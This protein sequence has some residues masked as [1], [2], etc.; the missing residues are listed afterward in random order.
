MHVNLLSLP[1]LKLFMDV[2]YHGWPLK[3]KNN[4][5]L[6]WHSHS[7]VLPSIKTNIILFS[8]GCSFT[9]LILTLIQILIGIR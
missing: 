7:F 2:L 3:K 5:N 1:L 4:N 9:P 6:M 8:V